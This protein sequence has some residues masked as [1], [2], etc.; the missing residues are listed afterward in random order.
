MIKSTVVDS[1]G[2]RRRKLPQ[3]VRIALATNNPTSATSTPPLTEWVK[4]RPR[5]IDGHWTSRR[6]N[7]IICNTLCSELILGTPFLARNHIVI[8]HMY[9]TCT[10]KIDGF[11]LL[12]PV[13]PL[14]SPSPP[15]IPA[16]FATAS[17][18]D[19]YT[20]SLTKILDQQS[21]RRNQLDNGA[22]CRATLCQVAALRACIEALA[23]DEQLMQLDSSLR[24]EFADLFRDEVPHLDHL[25]GD[26]FHRFQLRSN[27]V[28]FK[29]WQY[30]TPR[31]YQDAWRTLLQQHLNAGR[32]CPSSS[33]YASPAFL[34]PKADPTALPRL[35][36]DYRQLNNIT[37]PDRTPLPR[38]QDILSN[39]GKGRIWGKINMTNAFFQTRVHPDEIH[40]TAISTP[41]G[42]YEW[43]VM[44]MGCR[45]VP[46]THQ[47]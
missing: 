15:A 2:L 9:H 29:V 18:S 4:L 39:C 40:L 45:N 46:A 44:P 17:H 5:S 8:D 1:L 22:D 10:A 27:N 41:F 16:A 28:S 47:H 20:Q 7:A 6:V 33:P 19:L 13:P 43:T 24:F 30:S 31:R 14:V 35:V 37:I 25:P 32:L 36:C 38:V 42:L 23:S 3:P 11:D 21:S 34:I 12:K 26:V